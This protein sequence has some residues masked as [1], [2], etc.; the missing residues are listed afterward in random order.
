M[1][2]RFANLVN[3]TQTYSLSVLSDVIGK[4]LH[5]ASQADAFDISTSLI[6]AKPANRKLTEI[7][8]G[9][10]GDVSVFSSRTCRTHALFKSSVSDVVLVRSVDGVN[11]VAGQVW[12]LSS[13]PDKGQFALMS[14][15][16]LHDASTVQNGYALWKKSSDPYLLDLDQLI[17]SVTWCVFR[18]GIIRTLI[19]FNMRGLNAVDK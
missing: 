8:C 3:N 17:L 9:H 2:K 7:I 10:L 4:Q 14:L 6:D 12:A 18:P 5:D 16:S 15:W 1:V 13:V 19:P 11:F